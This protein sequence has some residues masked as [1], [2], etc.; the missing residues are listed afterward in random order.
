MAKL[1]GS[2]LQ[3]CCHQVPL[4]VPCRAVPYHVCVC[5][6]VL[7][8]GEGAHGGY[9]Q[10]DENQLFLLG[11]EEEEPPCGA[12]P[13]PGAEA[14]GRVRSRGRGGGRGCGAMAHHHVIA[15][16]P[17]QSRKS[18]CLTHLSQRQGK[19]GGR[20]EVRG[21]SCC[22][23]AGPSLT[24]C[25]FCSLSTA[26]AAHPRRCWCCAMPALPACLLCP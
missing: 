22:P 23:S 16:T 13:G 8:H 2:S 26:F 5:R 20:G 14:E 24:H 3:C 9:S 19:G 10:G 6:F 15:R 1:W 4:A 7:K 12:G 11:A 17:R 25:S 21:P 18:D